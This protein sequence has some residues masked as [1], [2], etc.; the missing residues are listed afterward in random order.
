MDGM[1]IRISLMQD[2][3]DAPRTTFQPSYAMSI[4]FLE[5]STTNHKSVSDQLQVI[6]TGLQYAATS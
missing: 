3:S 5:K 6:R 4:V 2:H 1:C